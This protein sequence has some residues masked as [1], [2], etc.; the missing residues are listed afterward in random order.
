[1]NA[2]LEYT[3][4]VQPVAMADFGSLYEGSTCAEVGWSTLGGHKTL[5]WTPEVKMLSDQYCRDNPGTT[6]PMGYGAMCGGEPGSGTAVM[7]PGYTGSPLLCSDP[8]TGDIVLAGLQSF[9]YSC[10]TPGAP[11]VYTNIGDL[12]DWVDYILSKYDD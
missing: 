10:L 4:Y 3:N 2:S 5:Q 6:G 12:R 11:S 1:M 7:C 9:T 8:G